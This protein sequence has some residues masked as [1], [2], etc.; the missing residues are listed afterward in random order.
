MQRWDI[1]KGK[2][3][4]LLMI[5]GKTE[6]IIYQTYPSCNNMWC[7]PWNEVLNHNYRYFYF[8]M[9]YF[10]L[11]FASYAIFTCYLESKHTFRRSSYSSLG[12]K[13]EHGSRTLKTRGG[14]TYEPQYLSLPFCIKPGL[15]VFWMDSLSSLATNR[16]SWNGVIL[17]FTVMLYF[18]PTLIFPN[19]MFY[20]NETYLWTPLWKAWGFLSV[21]SPFGS[22]YWTGPWQLL[23]QQNKLA[24]SV[25][26]I[27]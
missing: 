16:S 25:L 20:L 7:W 5:P 17:T 14:F 9:A 22:I 8:M 18:N 21:P 2:S 12:L 26:H 24:V 15:S 4:S 1:A 10:E 19:M 3:V 11:H 6:H 27:L 23:K 13:V